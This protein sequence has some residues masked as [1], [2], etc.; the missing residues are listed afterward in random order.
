MIKTGRIALHEYLR[1]VRTKRFVLG[2]LSV[3]LVVLAMAGLVI[4]IISLEN[5][6]T[7]VGYVDY[8]GLLDIPV[9]APEVEPPDKPVP[10]IAYEN[11]EAAHTAMEAG[12][13]KGYFVLPAD[14][15]T[16]GTLSLVHIEDVK[17]PARGQFYDLLTANLLRDTD[18]Q[19]T[20]RLL[21]GAEFIVISPDGERSISTE[22]WLAI[23]L[24]LVTG[25]LFVIAMF[26]ASGYLMQAVVEEKENRTIEVLLTSVSANQ[27][28]A[29]KIL[30][31]VAV[32]LTQILAWG[33]FIV[34]GTLVGQKYTD[35]LT[36][37]SIS[38]SILVILLLVLL[39][40][41]IILAAL[42]AAVGATVVEAREGQ[43]ISGWLSMPVWIPYMF[44]PLIFSSPNSTVA[45]ILSILPLT[46]PL[47]MLMRESVTI[48]P[49]WQIAIS[50]IVQIL[51]A[52][53]TIWL[54]GRAF[55]LGMLRYGKRLKWRDLFARS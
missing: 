51:V 16:T 20:A 14:Y 35:M 49:A 53:A 33:A 11:E 19:T 43:Q 30:G 45:V 29:G 3:P 32:G 4:L 44:L 28:M 2:L 17:S 37:T 31:D 54:A 41:F 25:I 38:P 34:I 6:T 42:M 24:P 36:G 22:N 18:P 10:F 46:A 27:F 26:S 12:E 21:E 1:H 9:P 40:S 13:I 50:A 39:P 55:R 15:L 5:D 48:L 23:I 47:A 52:I 7:P 8:C